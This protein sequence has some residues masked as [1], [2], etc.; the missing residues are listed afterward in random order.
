MTESKDVTQRQA[1]EVSQTESG[2]P[3]RQTEEFLLPRVNVYED[4]T[5]ITLTAD[6]PGVPSER[7]NL[8]VDNDTL[9]IEGEAVLDIPEGMKAV[10]AEVR[11]PRYRRSFTLSREL[12][13]DAIEANLKDGLLT[14]HL[15]KKASYQP[16]KI[17]IQ[18]A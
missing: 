2:Q 3:T 16:R 12:D 1:Q 9:L 6:L 17:Q 5:G 8:Q 4:K 7:L 11:N 10:Y 18:T 13:T 15:S 14:V